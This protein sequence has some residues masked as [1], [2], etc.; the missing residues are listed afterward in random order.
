[1]KKCPYCAEDIQDAAV[2]CRYCGSD[3]VSA[4]PRAAQRVI[5]ADVDI[6]IGSMITLMV[7]WAI[8]TVP[9]AI[10]VGIVVFVVLAVFS[11]LVR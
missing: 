8:A 9:V 1:M 4:P 6:P 3:Q 5:I 11:G 2:K 10:I 7:R